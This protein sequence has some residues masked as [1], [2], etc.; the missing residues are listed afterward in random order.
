MTGGVSGE[1]P[2]GAEQNLSHLP[3]AAE[4]VA[5][6]PRDLTHSAAEV[7]L[8][9]ESMYDRIINR[10]SLLYLFSRSTLTL[11]VQDRKYYLRGFDKQMSL[12]NTCLS[13]VV[14]RLAMS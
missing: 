9:P 10:L 4:Q 6:A 5:D 13:G 2:G 7:L 11:K 12:I 8:C 3:N 14:L 1:A